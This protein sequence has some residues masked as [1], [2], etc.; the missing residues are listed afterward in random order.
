MIG[1]SCPH[2]AVL[3]FTPSVLMHSTLM[4]GTTAQG[5]KDKLLYKA[6]GETYLEAE[7][8]LEADRTLWCVNMHTH[9]DIALTTATG[10]EL[11]LHQ[12]SSLYPVL[13]CLF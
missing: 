7:H 13:V 9:T 5:H 8:R 6:K 3:L 12:L 2:H 4:T 10:F 11:E 1:E